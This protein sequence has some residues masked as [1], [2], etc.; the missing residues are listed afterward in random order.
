TWKSTGALPASELPATAI[1]RIEVPAA[2]PT[3]G[4]TETAAPVSAEAAALED[5]PATPEKPRLEK[6]AIERDRRAIA[7]YE[8]RKRARVAASRAGLAYAKDRAFPIELLDN[9]AARQRYL[10]ANREISDSTRASE[11]SVETKQRLR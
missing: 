11:P 2:L 4:A 3:D 8:A 1:N 7:R 9:E 6:R 10:A 5:P